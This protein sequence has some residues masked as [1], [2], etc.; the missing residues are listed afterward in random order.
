[1]LARLGYDPQRGFAGDEALGVPPA[2]PGSLRDLSSEKRLD[3]ILDTQRQLA[4]GLGMKTRGAARVRTYPA[5]E[6][7][8]LETRR[9]PRGSEASDSPGWQQRWMKAGGPQPVTSG[10]KLK[11]IALKSDEV[12]SRLGDGALFDDALNTDHPPFAFRSGMGWRE[13]SA[14]ECAKLGIDV[15]QAFQ[16]ARSEEPQ[17]GKP[18]PQQQPPSVGR[19]DPEVKARLLDELRKRP[20]RSVTRADLAKMVMRAEG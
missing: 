5:W 1:M 6:L 14:E 12:W 17:A 4:H 3:L 7:V 9:V 11:L 8:R 19:M 13:V 16:P 15:T 20:A 18:V 10:T 2:E